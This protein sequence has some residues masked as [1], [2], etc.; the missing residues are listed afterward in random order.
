MICKFVVFDDNINSSAENNCDRQENRFPQ[1]EHRKLRRK[2]RHY[3]SQHRVQID[4]CETIFRALVC[5]CWH[6]W[7][8]DYDYD[9]GW[10]PGFLLFIH[11]LSRTKEYP[12]YVEIWDRVGIEHVSHRLD[13]TFWALVCWLCFCRSVL[14]IVYIRIQLWSSIVWDVGYIVQQIGT[15]KM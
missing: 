3:G 2:P 10:L 1:Q 15:E 11:A 5:C 4:L 8:D 6:R 12:T 14:I 9:Y 13:Y 7:E